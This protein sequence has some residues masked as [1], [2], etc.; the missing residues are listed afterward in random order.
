MH[1]Q[2]WEFQVLFHYFISSTPSLP[3]FLSL[4]HQGLVLLYL[5]WH[6]LLLF[7]V[8][9]KLSQVFWGSSW[10]SCI[11]GNW[12]GNANWTEVQLQLNLLP[13]RE[14]F[15]KLP[16][17]SILW[18]LCFARAAHRYILFF[19]KWHR[20]LWKLSQLPKEVGRVCLHLRE[21]SWVLRAFPFI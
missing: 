19:L 14:E 7:C 12:E 3:G 20:V 15:P 4:L 8:L 21:N 13:L 9:K 18:N 16:V 11:G 5:Q 6:F 2:H 10:F 1:I 17:Q